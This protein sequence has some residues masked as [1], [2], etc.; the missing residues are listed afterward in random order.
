MLSSTRGHPTAPA[1]IDDDRGAG[2]EGGFIRGEVD[3]HVGDLVGAAHAADGLP[4]MQLLDHLVFVV[5][6]EA[7]EIA[8]DE[9]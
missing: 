1:A 6:V 5:F 3:G 7:L 9:W 4:G 2:H 8:L